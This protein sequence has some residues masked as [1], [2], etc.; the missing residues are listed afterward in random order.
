MQVPGTGH[1][2]AADTL[3]EAMAAEP[4]TRGRFLRFA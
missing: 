3:R 1:R 4:A 2:I